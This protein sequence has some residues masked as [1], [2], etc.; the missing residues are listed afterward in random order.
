MHPKIKS[1]SALKNLRNKWKKQKK[2]VVFTNGC[3]DVLHFGHVS[4]LRK[5]KSQGDVLIVGLNTDDSVKRLKGA[6]RPVN[7]EL[8][9]A[10]ILSE[11]GC[12]DAVV[13]FREDTPEALIHMLKPDVLVKG[14]D[15]KKE[16]IVGSRFVESYGGKVRRI[17]FE[18]GRSTTKTIE[19]LKTS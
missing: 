3:F 18:P 16:K 17:K 10:E 7:K 6:G 12:V 1:L 19:K 15:W 14:A 13:F 8:D 4:Y 9:R 2:Q 5:A 11:F